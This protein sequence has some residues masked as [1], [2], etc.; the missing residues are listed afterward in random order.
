[1]IEAADREREVRAVLRRVKRLLLEGVPASSIAVIFRDGSAY[2]RLLREV[3]VEFA[4]PLMVEEGHPLTEAPPIA[5][6]LALL[7]TSPNDYQRRALVEMLR[8]PYLNISG[9]T[10]PTADAPVDQPRRSL[11]ALAEQLDALARQVGVAGGL[12][13]W[14]AALAH[15]QITP[16]VEHEHAHLSL[17]D[18]FEQF[19]AWITPLS[20]ALPHDYIAW[21]RER[22]V[23]IRQAALGA[24]SA[25]LLFHTRDQA[26]LDRFSLLLDQLDHAANLTQ[27]EPIPY[28]TFVTELE[29]FAAATRF[30]VPKGGVIVRSVLA[31]RGTTFDH[32]F[33]LGLS[34]GEFPQPLSEPAIYSRSERQAWQER[35]I[36]L[37]ARDAADEVTL[38]YEAITRARHTLTLSRT[39]L[40]EAGSSLAR[41]PYL[42][43]LLSLL[44]D[45]TIERV[46]A[47][48]VPSWE[49][50]A[51]PQEQALALAEALKRPADRVT[52]DDT[53][54][55][56][57]ELLD[58]Y[59]VW[60]H[61]IQA[62]QI[63][64][65][66]EQAV[67]FGPYDGIL[68]DPSVIAQVAQYF[69]PEHQWSIT[70][71]NNY[72]TCPFRFAAS[73]LLCIRPRHEPEDE[74]DS[75]RRGQLLHAIFSRA[76]KAW[77]QAQL[78]LTPENEPHLQ[79]QLEQA[80]T[81]VLTHAP[82][83]LGFAPS[84]FWEWE[85]S[86][87]RRVVRTALRGFVQLGESWSAFA[88]IAFE[89]GF[90]GNSSYPPL[91]LETDAGTVH[92]QGRIDRIDQRDD[93]ALAIVDYKS[94]RTPR[95][96]SESVEGY[97][98]QLAVYT[99]AL[100]QHSAQPVER[101]AFMHMGSGKRGAEIAQAHRDTALQAAR[102]RIVEVITLVRSGD[103]RVKPRRQCPTYC[104]FEVLCRK[105]LDKA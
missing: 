92:V 64:E 100:E 52:H 104:E 80:A 37:S 21:T 25:T 41:S 9:G 30:A 5:A 102:E 3:A 79:Q 44:T 33:L 48:S 24:E 2:T 57:T 47:G 81:A 85:Q 7:R 18:D 53:L 69:G 27:A 20:T 73:H 105:N 55:W 87:I 91:L 42:N 36:P 77:Q 46:R 71:L 72:V 65:Q 76:G 28:S 103:F 58:V 93:G 51:S 98:L 26:A 35:G 32:V 59:P 15:K 66:R 75:A 8:S 101:A 95:P 70:Q 17:S 60:A 38:F 13:R 34:E 84:P 19:I 29:S 39:R 82:E 63:E 6:L 31:A 22:L 11:A 83:Q 90:G 16:E 49:E 56:H 67:A 61:V 88:P 10:L 68:D 40:D 4:V 99:M 23:N 74:I 94:S 89:Q 97:D 43:N 54:L 45:I 78:R 14:R 12:A 96:L 62:R 50:A 1:L 86:E